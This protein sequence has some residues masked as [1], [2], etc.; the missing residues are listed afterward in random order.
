[1]EARLIIMSQ[2]TDHDMGNS[3]EEAARRST[4]KTTSATSF[5]SSSAGYLSP[6][7]VSSESKRRNQVSPPNTHNAIGNCRLP[8]PGDNNETTLQLFAP[9]D[10]AEKT[11]A[12]TTALSW[13]LASN[14]KTPSE[15]I[16][17][18]G[19]KEDD[20]N[21]DI[22]SHLEDFMVDES[23]ASQ[24]LD[25]TQP[26]SCQWLVTNLRLQLPPP[27]VFACPPA[28]QLCSSH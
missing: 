14:R 22:D 12:D 25:T 24:N 9:S 7:R 19:N 4:K 3:K 1:M 13:Q 8:T 2:A 20:N 11:L 28:F 27:K 10:D 23:N 17:V 6:M 21:D 26:V 16:E 18:N 15:V 5:A